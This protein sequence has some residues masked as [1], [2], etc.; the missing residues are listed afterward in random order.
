VQQANRQEHP[1]PALGTRC[2]KTLHIFKV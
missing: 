2:A 1:A